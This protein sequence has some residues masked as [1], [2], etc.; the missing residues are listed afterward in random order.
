MEQVTG[1][2]QVPPRPHGTRGPGGSRPP[3]CRRARP[4]RTPCRLT[5]GPS[6]TGLRVPPSR[7]PVT[8][9]DPSTGCDPLPASQSRVAAACAPRGACVG[10]PRRAPHRPGARSPTG[11][12]ASLYWPARWFF[13]RLTKLAIVKIPGISHQNLDLFSLKRWHAAASGL[14][15][16]TARPALAGRGL[17]RHLS[18]ARAKGTGGGPT[19]TIVPYSP[20]TKAASQLGPRPR[21]KNCKNV[22]KR[23]SSGRVLVGRTG[24]ERGH[25][26]ATGPPRRWPRPRG[27]GPGAAV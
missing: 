16:G 12:D 10:R 13:K 17:C 20:G 27:A 11:P 19:K 4:H 18:A 7:G 15:P 5:R 3:L 6:A 8:A 14:C 2:L 22:C 21:Q 9:S 26:T 24:G 25:A 23:H 1:T